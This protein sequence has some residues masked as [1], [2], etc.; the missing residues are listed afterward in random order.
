MAKNG[1]SKDSAPEEVS[2]SASDQ[3]VAQFPDGPYPSEFFPERRS[4]DVDV[5]DIENPDK[6]YKGE[7]AAPLNAETWVILDGSHKDVPDEYDGHLAAVTAYPT[8]VIHDTDTGVTHE[9]MPKNGLVTVKER[10]QGAV[11]TLPMEAFKSVH[12]N[13]RAGVLGYA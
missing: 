9:E 11:L 2:S 6:S 4:G 5:A 10:S 1:K 7:H 12:P 13:G 8:S 3:I